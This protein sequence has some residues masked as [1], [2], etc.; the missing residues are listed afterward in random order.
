MV[1]IRQCKH[2]WSTS[3][4][5]VR[6]IKASQ[7][8]MDRRESYWLISSWPGASIRCQGW[9][10]FRVH[11]NQETY[12]SE[13]QWSSSNL[14]F[15]WLT[16]TLVLSSVA[17]W[18]VSHQASSTLASFH[19]SSSNL[20]GKTLLPLCGNWVYYCTSRLSTVRTLFCPVSQEASNLNKLKNCYGKRDS[21]RK[22]GA[23]F[24]WSGTKKPQAMTSKVTSCSNYLT[25]SSAKDF[26]D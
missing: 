24:F 11:Y 21:S 15:Q 23:I 3:H 6:T 20:A 10:M 12:W 19:L 9:L 26:R 16:E 14:S 7:I 5:I 22:R 18:S 2:H 25:K 1:T 4:T 8:W 13:M 17:N